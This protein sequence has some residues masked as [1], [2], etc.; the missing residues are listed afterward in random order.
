MVAG[1]AC[2]VASFCGDARDEFE[3]A[4]GWSWSCEADG[5]A[6]A[7]GTLALGAAASRTR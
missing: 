3:I 2:D 1:G 6:G 5:F 7:A 4:C